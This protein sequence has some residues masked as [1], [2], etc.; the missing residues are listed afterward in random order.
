MAAPIFGD[1][2]GKVQLRNMDWQ[3]WNADEEPDASIGWLDGP[4]L[5]DLVIDPEGSMLIDPAPVDYD[6]DPA[7]SGLFKLVDT[8]HY[9]IEDP[10]GSQLYAVAAVTAP[11]VCPSMWELANARADFATRTIVGNDTVTRTFND[12]E[13]QGAYG[14]R[15]SNAPIWKPRTPPTSTYWV[16]AGWR[17]AAS[18]SSRGSP[19]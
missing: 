15:R 3:T 10:R 9:L 14:I 12:P 4:M 17:C 16:P 1:L 19:P 8:D 5:I 6:E 13:G 18:T 2:D 11:E 7:G